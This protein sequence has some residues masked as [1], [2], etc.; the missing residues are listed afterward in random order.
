MTQTDKAKA[1]KAMHVRGAPLMLYNIWDAG[2]AR[3]VAKAGAKALATGSWSVAEAQGFPDGQKIPL[4]VLLQIAGRIVSSV[5]L[6]V[7]IDFEG[8]YATDPAQAATN[9]KRLIETGAVGL[10]FEDQIVGG[11]GLHPVEGQVARIKA[12]RGA[13]DIPFF[14]NA[15][16]DLFLRGKPET[17]AS[18]VADAV[19]RGC[20][21]AQAG[22][23]GFFV[24]GLT[25]PA[26]IQKVCEGVDLPVNVMMRGGLT[27]EA[28]AQVGVARI[29][30]GPGPY[31]TAIAALTE[32]AQV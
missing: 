24:P 27:R 1:F 13:S 15:R 30:H 32:T 23:D 21:Y 25:D 20:A 6:P 19:A 8:A 7:S 22:A 28:A 9:V 26:L 2:T 5:D 16:T 10:N 17:H 3:A 31:A 4:D 14:I 11:E 29:S 18:L 12:I